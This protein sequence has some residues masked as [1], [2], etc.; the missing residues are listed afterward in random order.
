M[1]M[2]NGVQYHILQNLSLFIFNP[3]CLRFSIIRH[4]NLVYIR[5]HLQYNHTHTQCRNDTEAD[6]TSGILLIV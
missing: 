1:V 6:E 2:H 4:V 5:N 3:S